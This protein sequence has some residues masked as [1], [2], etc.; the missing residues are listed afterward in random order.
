[1]WCPVFQIIRRVNFY[2][3]FQP[4]T[5]RGN[6]ERNSHS[7][8]LD[9]AQGQNIIQPD[10]QLP[11]LSI[12]RFVEHPE[13]GAGPGRWVFRIDALAAISSF[14]WHFRQMDQENTDGLLGA[15]F[16]AR[17]RHLYAWH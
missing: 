4:R 10:P 8:G 12:C 17:K 1:M 9:D 16:M 3:L 13:K 11:Y 5:A 14:G 15:G 6:L 7:P 2:W